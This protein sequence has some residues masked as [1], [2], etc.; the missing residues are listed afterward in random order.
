V[1][2]G[3]AK[4]RIFTHFAHFVR[5]FHRDN[6]AKIFLW[7]YPYFRFHTFHTFHIVNNQLLSYFEFV[8]KWLFSWGFVEESAECWN[9]WKIVEDCGRK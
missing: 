7:G 8:E 6:A 1:I 2:F 9:L 5:F 4:I 3:I